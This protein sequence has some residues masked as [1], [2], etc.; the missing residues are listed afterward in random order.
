M[1]NTPSIHNIYSIYRIT[2]LLNNKQYIGF[3]SL[4]PPEK[5]FLQHCCPRKNRNIS[6][7]SKSIIKYGQKNFRFEILMQ[8][9]DKEYILTTEGYFINEYN[10]IS[11][12]GYN[13]THGGE[14]PNHSEES[15][16][17]MSNIAKGKIIAENAKLK[18]SIA[19]KGKKLSKNHRKNISIANKGKKHSEKTK[20][21]ISET[22]IGNKN[23]MYG[24]TLSKEHREK[25][26]KTLKGRRPW[27]KGKKIKAS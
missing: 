17:K 26:S 19:K 13:L 18:M 24:K 21:K 5:R 11:P 14:F 20:I 27:N 2:N 9:Y 16:L 15:K 22:K 8:G 1:K 23:P 10:T 4:N 6:A 25:I 3:T 7:I 12:I